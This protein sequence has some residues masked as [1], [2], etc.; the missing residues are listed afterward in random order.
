MEEITTRA[1]HDEDSIEDAEVEIALLLGDIILR[2]Y[3]IIQQIEQADRGIE[4]HVDDFMY[5]SRYNICTMRIGARTIIIGMYARVTTAGL[6]KLEA[7]STKA[8]R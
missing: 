2:H 4:E 3:A 5:S 1:A 8:L 6:L 7:N